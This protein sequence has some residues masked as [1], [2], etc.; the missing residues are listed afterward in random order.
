MTLEADIT[1]L[2]ELPLFQTMPSSR[3]KLVAL[4]SEKLYFEAGTPMIEEGERSESVYVILHGEVEFS[5]Q[6]DDGR[7]RRFQ[8]DSG[9]IIG[10]VSIL[11]GQRFAGKVSAKSDVEALRL[12]KD[13]FLEL[14]ETVPDFSLALCRDLATRVHRLANFIL[15]E[16]KAYS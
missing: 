11:S 13:L 12:P 3:L 8:K 6:S 2:R 15:H 9:S 10:D 14:L 7:S 1:C 4:M 5:H 16:D